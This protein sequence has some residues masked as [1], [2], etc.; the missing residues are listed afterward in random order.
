[1]KLTTTPEIRH[2]ENSF[3]FLD[4]FEIDINLSDI[5]IEE[6]EEELPSDINSY[7]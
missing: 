7:W 3:K 2:F 5:L 4:K 6:L 1:M